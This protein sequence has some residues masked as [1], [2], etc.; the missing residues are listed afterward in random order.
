MP[1]NNAK[2]KHKSHIAHKPIGGDA[3][4]E[5]DGTGRAGLGKRRGSDVNKRRRKAG[6][7]T[8][9]KGE[10]SL[11]QEKTEQVNGTRSL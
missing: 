6:F 1:I 10:D 9:G 2:I 11:C 8:D 4:P 7:G 5:G 3:M